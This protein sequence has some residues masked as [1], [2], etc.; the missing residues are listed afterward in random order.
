M[1]RA[2]RRPGIGRQALG[3]RGQE[4]RIF[5]KSARAAENCGGASED[6]PALRF[7]AASDDEHE[8]GKERGIKGQKG[9][10]FFLFFCYN[11]ARTRTCMTMIIMCLYE[12]YG[13]F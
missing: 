1:E 5:E 10:I 9:T 2:E 11:L 13:S 3:A 8:R 12:F 7:G 4:E 6:P